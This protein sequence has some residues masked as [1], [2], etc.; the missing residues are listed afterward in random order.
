MSD[1]RLPVQ[2][3]DTPAI[4]D[5][6]FPSPLVHRGIER[7]ASLT[8]PTQDG[9]GAVAY[10][11]LDWVAKFY[12]RESEMHNEVPVWPSCDWNE[13]PDALLAT[14]LWVPWAW[15]RL[16]EQFW[17]PV[18]VVIEAD[19]GGERYDVNGSRTIIE[20][21][22]SL[23]EAATEYAKREGLPGVGM[24]GACGTP[25]V[26][27]TIDACRDPNSGHVEEWAMELVAFLATYAEVSPS[28]RGIRLFAWDYM[29]GNRDNSL[30]TYEGD[31]N[32][33]GYRSRVLVHDQ[34]PLWIP[35]GRRLLGTPY[36]I[37]ERSGEIQTLNDLIFH[38]MYSIRPAWWPLTM[39]NLRD[40]QLFTLPT[41][42]PSLPYLG[43][44]VWASRTDQL[45]DYPAWAPPSSA[46]TLLDDVVIARRWDGCD[47]ALDA[48]TG[49]VRWRLPASFSGWHR[50]GKRL[51]GKDDSWLY[52]IDAATG[53]VHSKTHLTADAGSDHLRLHETVAG[54]DEE[55]SS[56]VLPDRDSKWPVLFPGQGIMVEWSSDG[57]TLTGRDLS[58]NAPLWRCTEFDKFF[59]PLPA[60]DLLIVDLPSGGV[61]AID[62]KTGHF[63]WRNKESRNRPRLVHQGRIFVGDLVSSDGISVLDAKSGQE[64]DSLE[65]GCDLLLISS[66][67]LLMSAG[68]RVIAQNWRANTEFWR[69]SIDDRWPAGIRQAEDRRTYAAAWDEVPLTTP[70]VILDHGR[71]YLFTETT[72]ASFAVPRVNS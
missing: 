58:N 40:Q 18:P 15:G 35:T 9:A 2:P 63:R 34:W 20:P 23:W 12:L 36:A 54:A 21:S 8:R 70:R 29:A 10:A 51:C 16:E 4:F 22:R 56:I 48:A 3:S 68:G 47:W 38:C 5:H 7:L 28:G 49:T 66:N 33:N 69:A 17:S 31:P 61:G 14:N 44:D 59:S 32:I 72:I 67:Q 39:L 60:D 6:R 55:D 1:E 25:L 41:G 53:E 42:N 24:V 43:F 27:V 13:I 62:V 64:I 37:L 52:Q 71:I 50:A 65:E 57:D 30:D 19:E 46:I 45:L 26:L 11:E